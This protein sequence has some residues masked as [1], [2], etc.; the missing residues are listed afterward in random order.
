M[1]SRKKVERKLDDKL[2]EIKSCAHLP[3]KISYINE[4][5]TTYQHY[6]RFYKLDKKYQADAINLALYISGK[7]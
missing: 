4:Y 6:T 3:T 2:L 1:I 7:C 5:L